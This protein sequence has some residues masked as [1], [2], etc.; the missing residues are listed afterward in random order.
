MREKAS[1]VASGVTL[2]FTTAVPMAMAWLVMY[3]SDVGIS[4]KLM[5]LGAGVKKLTTD[6]SICPKC[7]GTGKC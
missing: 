3:L 7:H 1:K 5:N 2:E 4:F 6:V